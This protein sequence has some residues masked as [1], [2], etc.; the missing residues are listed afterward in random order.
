MSDARP[1]ANPLKSQLLE[2][3]KEHAHTT[4][5]SNL[6]ET[7][8]DQVRVLS[9]KGIESV[10]GL[11]LMRTLESADTNAESGSLVRNAQ[12]E[13]QRLLN[14]PGAVESS[15]MDL[16]REQ[17]SLE[18]QKLI[19]ERELNKAKAELREDREAFEKHW[20]EE[21]AEDLEPSLDRLLDLGVTAFRENIADPEEVLLAIR[22]PLI[23]L[24]RR[25]LET[26]AQKKLSSLRA[27]RVEFLERRVAKI[28][29]F[30]EEA[31]IALAKMMPAGQMAEGEFDIW[32]SAY[33]EL[34]GLDG[35][36]DHF[37]TRQ[38]M[39]QG[40]FELNQELRDAIRELHE[41]RRETDQA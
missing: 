15:T 13:F 4:S 11:A 10:V 37:E 8:R 24:F 9:S 14:E 27:A 3:F 5:L 7:G 41:A 36:E 35:S 6:Q 40:M 32:P 26:A 1:L 23:H 28:R 12:R 16:Q 39:M 19:L 33:K 18:S 38:N 25:T 17:R 2:L 21:M 29:A 20:L 30:L 34:Q 31:N 22:G